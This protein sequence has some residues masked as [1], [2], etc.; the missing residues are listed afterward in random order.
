S[1]F[2]YGV[3]GIKL[4]TAAR[5]ENNLRDSA[6]EFYMG[7]D[8][9]HLLDFETEDHDTER[10]NRLVDY[11][12]HLYSYIYTG[13]ILH[14]TMLQWRR[15][16]YDISNRPDILF[17][18]FNVG[19]DQSQPKPD[20]VCGGSRIK[21]DENWYTF[22]AIGFDF[23]YSGELV[24]S[25][26]YWEERFITK[27]DKQIS[28]Q[29]VEALQDGVSN[30]RRPARGVQEEDDMPDLWSA[31]ASETSTPSSPVMATPQALLEAPQAPQPKSA[32]AHT[33]DNDAPQSLLQ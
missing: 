24:R 12:N 29:D 21:V 4:F 26:P 33:S 31:P 18:L 25:F 30:C 19:F 9:E 14:Q 27:R 17:T 32:P 16:G 11:R 13:C 1:Q 20:P 22:G 28:Q 5:V 3:N 2:S 8:Y 7:K 23:Y 6:S 15:A 10:Y